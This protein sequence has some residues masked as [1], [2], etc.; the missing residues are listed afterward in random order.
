MLGITFFGVNDE[1]VHGLLNILAALMFVP[2][3]LMM[4]GGLR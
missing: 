3:L 2:L 4:I 1:S